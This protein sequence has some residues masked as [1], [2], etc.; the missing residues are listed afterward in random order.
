MRF[1]TLSFSLALAAVSSFAQTTSFQPAPA[2]PAVPAQTPFVV[3]SGTRIPLAMINSV[4]THNSAQGDRVYLQT[5]FPILSNGRI[6]IPPGSFV[7]GTVTEVKRPGK[8]KGRGELYLRFDSLTLPNGVTRDFRARV[9]GIDGRTNER[10]DRN[11][12]KIESDS[13]KGGDARTIGIAAASGA[14]LGGIVG[15]ASNSAGK[16]VGVGAAAG[17]AAG[18]MAVLLTRGPD[19]TLP[20]GSTLE[21]I[22]D[23]PLSFTGEE[24]DFRG[25]IPAAN[26]TDG[27]SMPA[28][29][30]KSGSSWRRFP[31]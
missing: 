15:A 6:V 4:N 31:L 22:L 8:I 30:Q 19:A 1:R 27:G 18:L 7:E 3:Q 20:K 2:A 26:F 13:N 16:G 17:A 28:D 14:S 23:R 29:N 12:G 10:L 5:V 9:G 11:E 21:M 24:V 25:G